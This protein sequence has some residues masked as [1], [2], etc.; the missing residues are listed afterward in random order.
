TTWIAAALNLCASL[1]AWRASGPE[2]AAPRVRD[3]TDAEPT[4]APAARAVFAV[5][6]ALSGFSALLL[7]LAWVRLFGLV[8]GSSVYS[9]S[10]VLGVY[11]LGLALGSA[12][13]VPFLSRARA[14]PWWF[15][16]LQSAIALASVAGIHAYAG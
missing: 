10:A 13:M 9:F 16:L 3:G 5:L 1:I 8:L 14:A 7:Q 2:R 6:F 12:A 15:A 4:L 11:L